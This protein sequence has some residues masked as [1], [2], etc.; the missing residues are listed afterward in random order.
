MRETFQRPAEVRRVVLV[1]HSATATL[2]FRA[3]LI[4]D[5]VAAGCEVEVLAPDWTEAQLACLKAL[6]AQGGAFPLAR[7]GLNP[8]EDLLTLL[9]LWRH[10]RQRRPD[11]VFTYAAKTNVW[12]MLAAWLARVPRRVA[13]VAGL[14]FAFTETEAFIGLKRAYIRLFLMWLYRI[15]LN[16]ADWVVVQNPDD[17]K[18]LIND[19][20]VKSDKIIR[21]NG[22]GV[23]LN[24]WSPYPPHTQPITFTLVARLLREKGVLEFL[25]AAARIKARHPQA[26]FWLLGPLDD[27]PGGLKEA[28]L[29]PWLDDGTVEWPGAVDVKPWLAQTSVFVLPSYREGVPRSTQEAMAMGRPVITTDAPGCRE[30][31]VEGVNGFLIPPRDVEALEQAM[32][33]FIEKPELIARMGNASRRLAEERFDVRKTNATLMKV[34]SRP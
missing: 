11:V 19:C 28:D 33:R 26:R 22:T 7:T 8:L 29:R 1:G 17:P 20:G 12:G 14:G 31:V 3:P 4:A 27:N 18:V 32:L 15:A 6:G 9:V 34:F 10:M 16:R 30:T 21:V 24:E 23:A 2:N 13:M 25:Q 5:L